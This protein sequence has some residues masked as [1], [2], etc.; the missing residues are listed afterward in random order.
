MR[1]QLYCDVDS[2]LNNHWVR[3]A[4][5]T[6]SKIIRPEAFTREEVMKDVPLSNAR[7]GLQLLHTKYDIH[8]LSAR[9]WEGAYADTW[10]WLAQWELPF[11]SINIIPTA[12]DKPKFLKN[13]QCDLLIDDFS[14]GQE[15]VGSYKRHYVTVIIELQKMNI[16]ILV[17]KHE[18][19][20]NEIIY[21]FNIGEI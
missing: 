16:P 13:K 14:S 5:W 17:F 12:Y 4:K 8:I 3:I 15:E 2:T 9:N 19:Y 10:D 6:S 1:K 21:M 20:W 7:V 11:E 18:N